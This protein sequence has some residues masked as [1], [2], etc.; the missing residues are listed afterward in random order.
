M[1]EMAI[2]F[3]AVPVKWPPLLVRNGQYSDLAGMDGVK[4]GIGKFAEKHAPDFAAQ[5]RI[6]FGV[7]GDLP[8]RPFNLVDECRSE[9]GVLHIVEISGFVDLGF[10]GLMDYDDMRHFLRS[11]ARARTSSAGND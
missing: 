1:P 11:L 7:S 10:S 5:L 3:S 2:L 8:D 6:C 4:E 9:A